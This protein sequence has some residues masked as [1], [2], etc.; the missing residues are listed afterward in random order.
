MNGG[1]LI[2]QQLKKNGVKFLF[3]LC[4]G[5]IAP[6]YVEAEKAGIRVIDVRNEATAVFAADAVSRLTSITG[7]AVVTAGP[8]ITNSITALKNA[9]LAQSPVLVIAGATATLLHNRGALQDIDQAAIVKST[10]KKVIQV[11][12]VK[13]LAPAV[14]KAMTCAAG[15]VPGPVFMECPVD[16]L[17]EESMVRDWYLSKSK[18]KDKSIKEKL[19]NWY[20]LRHIN[21]LFKNTLPDSFR[22][23]KIKKKPVASNQQLKTLSTL[24]RQSTR[25]VM[26][27]GSGGM[28]ETNRVSELAEAINNLG[29]PVY[30]SGMARGLLGKNHP[31]HFRHKRK[32]A[33]KN[34]DL[35][36]LAGL[37]CDFRLNYGKELSHLAKKIT[38]NLD[39]AALRKNVSPRLAIHCNPAAC[40]LSLQKE[41]DKHP[42]WSE[43]KEEL[44]AREALREV[45]IA[46]MAVATGNGINPVSLF[47]KMDELLPGNTTIVSDGGD[48]AATSS[49]ILKPRKPLSWL[50]SGVFG[51]LGVGA[52]FALGA[53]LCHPDDYVFIVYGDGSCGYS[54]IEFDTFTKLGLKI[55]AIVGNNGSWAQVARDQVN[56]LGADTATVI[57]QSDYH[58]IAKS[59]GAHG[60]KVDTLKDFEQAIKNAIESMDNGTPYLI[61]AIIESTAFR[62]G[63]I[64]I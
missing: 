44:K 58:L 36:I 40:I 51:T 11:S 48:F 53:A 34:A 18:T 3:T 29:I 59:F 21:R 27:L 23:Y 60:E 6:I 47:K 41:L 28:M 45:A 10:V 46:E 24:I 63:S 9:Q 31:V 16:L 56:F 62:D 12:R 19:L 4:G 54:I 61:N 17:Y 42:S 37:P 32:E 38:I 15:E 7:L 43:W 2:A 8:G 30:L 20:I 39:K 35:I 25:P 26:V 55:C 50:D 52:G 1:T 22:L 13:Q 49:Y 64:S 57:P 33:L 14:Q 5:H